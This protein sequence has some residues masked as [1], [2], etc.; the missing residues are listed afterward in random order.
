MSEEDNGDP[1]SADNRIYRGALR[2]VDDKYC[3]IAFPVFIFQIIIFV[4]L[5]RIPEA[6]AFWVRIRVFYNN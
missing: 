5:I 1:H 2:N 4:S 3:N 6:S